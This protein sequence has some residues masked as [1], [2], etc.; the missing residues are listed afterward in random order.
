M[1]LSFVFVAILRRIGIDSYPITIPND[2]DEAV[3]VYIPPKPSSLVPEGLLIDVPDIGSV[4][5]THDSG[6][7]LIREH[8]LVILMRVVASV[9]NSLHLEYEL[10]TA[11]STWSGDATFSAFY[12]VTICMTTLQRDLTVYRPL[13]STGTHPLD[14]V[15]VSLDQLVPTLDPEPRDV[16]S[17]RINREWELTEQLQYSVRTRSGT[18]VT[19]FVGMVVEVEYKGR[20]LIGCVYSWTVRKPP[21]SF[22]PSC[23]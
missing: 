10:R 1:S 21:L 20:S 9:A 16:L 22:D 7:R 6:W 5:P 14:L 23:D 18:G 17:Q 11:A 8:I 19:G 3:R 4:K 15:A 12:F 13:A 2:P